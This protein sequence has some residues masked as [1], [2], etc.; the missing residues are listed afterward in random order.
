MAPSIRIVVGILVENGNRH[1]RI[2]LAVT[3]AESLGISAA[4][5]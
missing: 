5:R 1:T 3:V 2:R 4:K